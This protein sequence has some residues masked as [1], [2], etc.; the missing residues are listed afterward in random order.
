MPDN[1]AETRQRGALVK[2]HCKARGLLRSSVT[3]SCHTKMDQSLKCL[4]ERIAK[5]IAAREA[6]LASLRK[7]AQAAPTKHDRE[8]ILLTLAVL[9]EEL[10]GWKQIAARIEQTVLFEPR[11]HRAIRMPA[12]R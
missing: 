9:D 3:S 8:R 7:N 12:L 1:A 2:A 4:R 6:A 10:A 5:Q 11:N